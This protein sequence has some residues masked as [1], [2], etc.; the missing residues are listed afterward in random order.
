ML[1]HLVADALAEGIF[2]VAP[3][4]EHDVAEPRPERVVDRIVDDQFAVGPDGIGLLETAVPAPDA[5]GEDDE[6]RF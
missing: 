1:F 6:G 5:A 2:D 3:D 4:Q